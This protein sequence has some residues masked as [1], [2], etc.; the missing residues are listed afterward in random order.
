MD[1]VGLFLAVTVLLLATLVTIFSFH[2]IDGEE[3]EE[4][5]Y[6]LL[7]VMTATMIG[8]GCT[9]D[10]FNLWV[11]FE[12]MAITSYL[13]GGFL[14]QPADIAGSRRQIPGAVDRSVRCW[15]CWALRWC[16]P[17]RRR[18]TWMKFARCW[19]GSG[20]GQP[21]GRRA[22]RHRVWRQDGPGAHAHLAARR[23]FPGAQRDQRHAFGRGDRSRADCDA[24]RAG[25]PFG[26]QSGLGCAPA[27]LCGAQ[28]AGT[29]T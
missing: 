20:A 6:A 21:G 25:L 28:Y 5:Y 1:G 22:V 26:G 18:S 9:R 13:A 19:R 3:D 24:A 16:S 27:G 14:P 4:K 7:P 11:W 8:L 12:A 23:P 29:A 15:C 10:L 17:R 2:Y